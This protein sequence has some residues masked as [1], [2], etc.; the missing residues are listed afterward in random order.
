MQIV[1]VGPANSDREKRSGP[2]GSS[3]VKT[4]RMGNCSVSQEKTSGNLRKLGLFR[5]LF[6]L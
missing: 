5:P 3:T 4:Q 1:Q 6:F 2:V